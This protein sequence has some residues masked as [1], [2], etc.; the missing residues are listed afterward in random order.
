MGWV[1]KICPW[2]HATWD[3]KN[4]N[5]PPKKRNTSLPDE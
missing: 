4:E 2:W 3:R 5:I 1:G